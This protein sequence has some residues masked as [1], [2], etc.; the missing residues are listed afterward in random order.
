M[1]ALTLTSLTL[2]SVPLP[3]LAAAPRSP[4]WYQHTRLSDPVASSGTANDITTIP[5][6]DFYK[7]PPHQ[8]LI[9]YLGT[10]SRIT[11]LILLLPWRLGG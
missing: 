3:P 1:P 9:E 10:L 7:Q 4:T 6:P 2:H 5:C 8:V 11:M